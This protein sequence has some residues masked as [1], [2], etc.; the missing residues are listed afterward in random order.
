MTEV[1]PHSMTAEEYAKV[2]AMTA[3]IRGLR[4][5]IFGTGIVGFVSSLTAFL[6]LPA[7]NSYRYSSLAQQLEY[8]LA[9]AFIVSIPFIVFMLFL[10]YR[11]NKHIDRLSRGRFEPVKVIE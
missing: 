4:M 7:L 9:S 6:Y 3:R 10:T 2:V 1:S 5:A 11:V 8:A